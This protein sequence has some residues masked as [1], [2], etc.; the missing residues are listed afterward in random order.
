M[1]LWMSV[2]EEPESKRTRQVLLEVGALLIDL[3]ATIEQG[4]TFKC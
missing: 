3:Q 2:L 4:V 1:H